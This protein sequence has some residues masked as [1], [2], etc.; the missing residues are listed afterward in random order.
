MAASSGEDLAAIPGSAL[1]GPSAIVF[2]DDIE[3]EILSDHRVVRAITS[4]VDHDV[5]L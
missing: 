1:N 5:R 4:E 3:R 2:G